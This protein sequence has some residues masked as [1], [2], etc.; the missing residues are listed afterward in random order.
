MPA[1]ALAWS[2]SDPVQKANLQKVH[3]PKAGM[4]HKKET[5]RHTWKG[6]EVGLL[7][8]VGANCNASIGVRG[9]RARDPLH[10]TAASQLR[11]PK[12]VNASL[13]LQR[14][15]VAQRGVK[16][17]PAVEQANSHLR[18]AGISSTVLL[19]LSAGIVTLE[20][21][22]QTARGKRSF[23]YNRLSA[24]FGACLTDSTEVLLLA[25]VAVIL[26]LAFVLNHRSKLRPGPGPC[27]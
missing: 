9:N 22:R 18:A 16:Q 19:N 24:S 3:P 14:A 20:L 17:G 23:C 15:E 11:S 13:L 7:F 8:S 4:L 10:Q 5:G 6:G 21:R 25:W 1:V 2:S 27:H 26:L 12:E